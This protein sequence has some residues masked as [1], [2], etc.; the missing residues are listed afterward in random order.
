MVTSKSGKHGH[1]NVHVA[2]CDIF[3]G[4]M[5]DLICSSTEMM[6]VPQVST[7]EYDVIDISDGRVSLFGGAGKLEEVTVPE[8]EIGAQI[9]EAFERADNVVVSCTKARG[10][11]QSKQ[12]LRKVGD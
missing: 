9:R 1:T 4:R 2:G 10:T 3:T 12:P 8:G 6:D 7:V 11:I 5:Y